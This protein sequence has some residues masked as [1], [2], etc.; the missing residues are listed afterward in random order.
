MLGSEV[1]SGWFRILGRRA[2][3]GSVC[4]H[5]ITRARMR[6]RMRAHMCACEDPRDGAS[7]NAER[8][9]IKHKKQQS[10]FC[11][12][13]EWNNRQLRNLISPVFILASV[14]HLNTYNTSAR[15]H[16]RVRA[17]E[18]PCK[19]GRSLGHASVFIIASVARLNRYNTSAR[20]HARTHA[21]ERPRKTGR[22]LGH[23]SPLII[24]ARV[25]DHAR[26]EEASATPP[27]L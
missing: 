17:R 19:T 10:E 8:K 5:A 13:R 3:L 16:A 6:A 25:K 18:R 12:F 20:M 21:R 7:A 15:M 11:I 23:A 24:R 1:G 22:S 26:R 27:P 2:R 9:N 4:I 14:A